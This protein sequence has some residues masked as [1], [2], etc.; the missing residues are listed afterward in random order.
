VGQGVHITLDE[1]LL[2]GLVK[3]IQNAVA[4]AEWDLDLRMPAG[5]ATAPAEEGGRPSIN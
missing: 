3:L 4:R 5:L 2:H 1:N